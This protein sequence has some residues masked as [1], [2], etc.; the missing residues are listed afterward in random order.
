MELAYLDVNRD[1]CVSH[2]VDQSSNIYLI[3]T[4]N[5]Q[6]PIYWFASN[7]ASSMLLAQ[8]LS[9]FIWTVALLLLCIA[10]NKQ[11]YASLCT[12]HE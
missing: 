9:I 2:L 10:S 1:V 12:L 8:V 11:L 4:K 7:Y 3:W 6:Y 5:T